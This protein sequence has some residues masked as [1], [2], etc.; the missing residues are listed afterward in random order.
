MQMGR[1]IIN[2]APGVVGLVDFGGVPAS[3]PEHILAE[4]R[5]REHAD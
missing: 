3:M 5:T 2:S 1:R 4:F